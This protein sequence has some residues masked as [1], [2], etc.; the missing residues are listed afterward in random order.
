MPVIRLATFVEIESLF[1]CANYDQVIIIVNE[2][3]QALSSKSRGALNI[4]EL[5]Q[6]LTLFRLN[7]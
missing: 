5:L 3:L 7:S 2:K 4:E 1:E 6:R